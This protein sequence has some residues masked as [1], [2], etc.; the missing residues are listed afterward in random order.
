MGHLYWRI[1]HVD[2]LKF[3]LFVVRNENP[4]HIV[5][6]DKVIV[7]PLGVNPVRVLCSHG[8]HHLQ[9]KSKIS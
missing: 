6:K 3:V 2:H 1:F 9:V 8:V 4:L 7:D 5:E